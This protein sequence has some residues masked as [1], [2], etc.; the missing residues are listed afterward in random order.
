L[1]IPALTTNT[2]PLTIPNSGESVRTGNLIS[3]STANSEMLAATAA[4][5]TWANCRSTK[6]TGPAR[7]RMA[8]KIGAQTA[9]PPHHSAKYGQRVTTPEYCSQL[10]DVHNSNNTRLCHIH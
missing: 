3:I 1:N 4:P 6:V 5:Q 8:Q 2:M 10:V 7:R 9:S